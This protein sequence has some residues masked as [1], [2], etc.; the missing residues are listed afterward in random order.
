MHTHRER[1]QERERETERQKERKRETMTDKPIYIYKQPHTQTHTHNYTLSN[2]YSSN[3][4]IQIN[5]FLHEHI[6]SNIYNHANIVALT[7]FRE[8]LRYTCNINNGYS[9]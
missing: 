9:Y 1:E 4:R 6:A 7:L 8:L 3:R 5:V 2:T